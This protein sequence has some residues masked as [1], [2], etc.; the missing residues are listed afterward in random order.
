MCDILT[1]QGEAWCNYCHATHEQGNDIL[2][3]LKD[4]LID[5][6][7]VAAKEARE[8]LVI[9]EIGYY[10]KERFSQTNEC[11][12]E[13]NARFLGIL[14]SKLQFLDIVAKN[15]LSLSVW[16]NWNLVRNSTGQN[17]IE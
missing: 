5:R 15:T 13:D 14:H 12:L 6:T 3:I 16:G 11:L 8:K 7:S 9:G 17:Q 1:G 4:F 10:D 2:V